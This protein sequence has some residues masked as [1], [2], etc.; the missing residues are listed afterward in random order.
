VLEIHK[1]IGGDDRGRRY[2]L[3]V[4]NKSAVILVTAFWEAYCEDL[5]AEALEHIVNH[6]PDASHL[7]KE[8]KKRIAR[9]LKNDA[10]DIAIWDLADA[11]WKA[12]IKSRLT[13]LTEER[14]RKLNTPKTENIDDLF[15]DAIG[16]PKVSDAWKWDRTKV[17]AARNKLNKYVSLRGAIAHRGQAASSCTK[18]QVDDY[19]AHVKQ[20]VGRTGGSVNSFVNTVTGKTLW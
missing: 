17:E 1:D 16:L 7:P 8:L 12:K 19:F 11:G 20:L 13:A 18:A 10:N 14:N 2:G 5:A 4:L 15:L 9:E 3:E 6:V